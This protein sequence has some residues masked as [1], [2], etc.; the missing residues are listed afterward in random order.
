MTT[1][2]SLARIATLA[3]ALLAA[4]AAAQAPPDP[5]AEDAVVLAGASAQPDDGRAA[6]NPAWTPALERLAT[7]LRGGPLADACVVVRGLTD[8]TPFAAPLAGAFGGDEAAQL[9]RGQGRALSV[10]ARLEALGVPAP[11]VRTAA[12]VTGGAVRGV[13]L[14]LV[15][16]CLPPER[17]GLDQAQVEALVDRRVDAAVAALSRLAAPPPE[18]AADAPPPPPRPAWRPWLEAGLDAAL[19]GVEPDTTFGP[20]LWAGAGAARGPWLG[21]LSAG[22]SV[23]TAREERLG[24][25]AAALFGVRLR[26]G[27]ELAAA[28]RWRVTTH[29]ASG[30]WLDQVLGA[31]AQAGW[32][33]ARAAVAGR[34]VC[35]TAGLEPLGWR[36]RRGEVRGGEAV[37]RPRTQDWAGVARLGVS[38][39]FE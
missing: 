12:P 7:C 1:A 37:P 14:R 22:L 30:P 36:W 11:R 39:R 3:A 9:A 8:E 2:R 10:Q 19:L 21:R 26:S 15:R 31:G 20:V 34:P 17:E 28:L 13:E 32:C 24:A 18:A 6:F 5:C 38:V 35:L 25:E 27:L 29:A 23:G 4:P 16:A 33:P